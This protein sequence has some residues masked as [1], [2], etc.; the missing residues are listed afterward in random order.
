MDLAR[1]F[2]LHPELVVEVVEELLEADIIIPDE[3]RKLKNENNMPK[4][5]PT[6]VMDSRHEQVCYANISFF[7][8]FYRYCN[9]YL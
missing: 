6:L 7:L 3:L 2:P 4:Y 8:F 5:D 1:A 9:F